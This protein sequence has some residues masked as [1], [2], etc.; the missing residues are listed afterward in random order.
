[1]TRAEV[2]AAARAAEE[3][4]AAI[5]R[6][7]RPTA[8][9]TA[10]ALAAYAAAARVEVRIIEQGAGLRNLTGAEVFWSSRGELVRV[11]Q[12]GVLILTDDPR[13]N[14]V[15]ATVERAARDVSALTA[16]EFAALPQVLVV[17]AKP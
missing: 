15:I 10:A 5:A 7:R 6:T 11:I 3:R 2:I 1:M 16:A 4:L 9:E 14:Y 8:E 12:V 17:E 13:G